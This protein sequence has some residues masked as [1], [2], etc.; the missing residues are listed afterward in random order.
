[1]NPPSLEIMSSTL[2]LKLDDKFFKRSKEI[3]FHFSSKRVRNSSSFCGTGSSYAELF[4]MAHRFSIGFKS[5][6]FP[7]HIPFPQ[8]VRTSSSKTFIVDFA[9]CALVPSC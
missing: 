7:G 1:M 8:T 4:N 5:G 9:V 3:E 6:L 2:F